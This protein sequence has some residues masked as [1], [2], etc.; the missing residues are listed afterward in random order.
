MQRLTWP[1]VQQLAWQGSLAQARAALSQLPDEVD[2]LAVGRLAAELGAIDVAIHRF[3]AALDADPEDAQA[4]E[5]LLAVREDLAQHEQAQALRARLAALGVE[6]APTP[7]PEQ[8]IA[9]EDAPEEALGLEEQTA[10]MEDEVG[11][12]LHALMNPS[13]AD[14]SRMLTLFLGRE[15]VHARQWYEPG[16]G[17]GYSPARQPLTPALLQAHLEGDITVGVYPVRLDGTVAF[18]A[19]DLDVTQGAIEASQRDP[20]QVPTLRRALREEAARL[21]QRLRA[22]GFDPLL[23]DS[24]WRGRHL[25]CFLSEPAPAAQVN[26]L[27]N[28]MVAAWSPQEPSLSLEGF[29]RQGQVASGGLGN[30]IKL[31]LGVHRRSGRRCWVLGDDGA[32]THPW[33]ALQQVRRASAQVLARAQS[34][35]GGSGAVRRA[36]QRPD[37]PSDQEPFTAAALIERAA[38]NALLGACPVL[39]ALVAQALREGVL[40]Y[41]ARVVLRHTLGHLEDGV[42]A[43][44]FVLSRCVGGA[45]WQQ[46]K[47]PLRGAPIACAS[48][49]ERLPQL[50]SRVA[51]ACAFEGRADHY[52]TPLLHLG[53]EHAAW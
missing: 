49:R 9:L 40:D 37:A 52:P 7:E 38:L 25:W 27:V 44:N 2:P 24:G 48:I 34:A 46:L 35:L 45:A 5:E 51:C 4:L 47:Q 15:G 53:E 18:F 6:V 22:L 26:A 11:A 29:P 43:A 16:R 50:T 31:P 13:R 23:E 12:E 30:L 39:G 41:D 28:Q 36:P 10:P 14:V 21:T 20:A 33:R 3:E 17:G 1:E 42:E 19:L 8:R 32:P